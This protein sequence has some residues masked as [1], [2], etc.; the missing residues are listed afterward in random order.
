MANGSLR[1]IALKNYAEQPTVSSRGEKLAYVSITDDLNIWRRDLLNPN[2]PAVEL[3]PSTQGQENAAFSP[4]GK[5]IVFASARSGVLGV[6]IS[7]VDGSNL[8]QVSNPHHLS[9]TPQWSPDGKKVAFDSLPND[10]WEIYIADVLDRIPRKLI[11]N[12][13]SV[14]RPHW[15]RDGKWIYFRSDEAGRTGVYRC[16]ASGGDAIQLSKD[17]GGVTPQESLDGRKVYFA[18]NEAHAVLKSVDLSPD[19]G[20]ESVVVGMPRISSS[21]LLTFSPG[22]IY[23]VPDDMPRSLRYFD[24]ASQKTHTIFDV[25][26]DFGSGLSVSPDG[27]WIIYSQL[28]DVNKDIMLVDHFH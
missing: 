10:R 3:V 9:G 8:V 24:F 7:N 18:S 16:P 4:D 27:R 1:H 12:I 2:S 20:Q 13:S 11:T 25:D 14:Y 26:K 23:F 22:G 21:E 15:S 6:W 5:R 28:G 19:P 17:P